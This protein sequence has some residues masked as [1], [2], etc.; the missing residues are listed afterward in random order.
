VG[1]DLHG[2]AHR[3]RIIPPSLIAKRSSYVPVRGAVRRACIQTESRRGSHGCY[4][5]V[6][7]GAPVEMQLPAHRLT[8]MH[9]FRSRSLQILDQASS[10]GGDG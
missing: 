7:R 2:G 6:N 3:P 4:S 5:F 9:I 10:S 1:G 8:C